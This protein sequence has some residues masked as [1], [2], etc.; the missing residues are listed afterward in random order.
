MKTRLFIIVIVSILIIR[1]PFAGAQWPAQRGM[2]RGQRHP[3]WCL[4]DDLR[5]TA[6]QV[7]KLKFIEGSYLND[8]TPLR[9]DLL[10]KRYELRR[11][12]S[13]PT[14]KAD[15]I[16]A[17]QG[18]AFVLETQIQ[19]KVIDYQLKV[20]EVLTPEQFKVWISRY[21]M[22]AGPMRGHGH[23]MGMMHR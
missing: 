17:K 2:G 4:P 23:G 19:E 8:I 15:D 16:R 14:S 6:E 20:R 11:L 7:E 5:L 13:D 22:G 3:R 12:I 9:N 21:R 18:E 10:N 1:V